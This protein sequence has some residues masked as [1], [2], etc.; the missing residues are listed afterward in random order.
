MDLYIFRHGDTKNTKSFI[1]RF[2]KKKNTS[3]LPILP[4]GKEAL[5]KI[6][7]YLKNIKTDANFTS[8]YLRCKQSSDIVG[9][10]SGKKFSIDSRIEELEGKIDFSVFRKKVASFLED[11]HSQNYSAVA[12]CT[13]GAVIS[14]LKHLEVDGNLHFFQVLSY[15]IPGKLTIIKNKKA[16]EKNFN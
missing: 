13:H 8:P 7:E 5:I 1:S 16:E 4:E 11:L 14:A 3:D 15:P 6:G 12:I 9:K 10:V 2:T